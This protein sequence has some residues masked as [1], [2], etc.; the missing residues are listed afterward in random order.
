[1]P[2]AFNLSQ[3]QTLQFNP[4]TSNSIDVGPIP[5]QKLTPPSQDKTHSHPL[6]GQEHFASC[7]HHNVSSIQPARLAPHQPIPPNTTAPTPIGCN[8]L[9]N[10]LHVPRALRRCSGKDAAERRDYTSKTGGVNTP[11]SA[12]FPVVSAHDRAKRVHM[13]PGRGPQPARKRPPCQCRRGRED[14]RSGKRASGLAVPLRIHPLPTPGVGAH[15]VDAP[16]STPP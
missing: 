6:T 3:D 1:M 12:S 11:R 5:T 15:F 4:N 16:G 2:P 10:R 14:R 8:L 7:E 13:R 9:K